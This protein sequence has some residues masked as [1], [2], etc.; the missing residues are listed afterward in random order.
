M[1]SVFYGIETLNKKDMTNEEKFSK[2]LQDFK[3]K[4]PS[5]T[6]ADLQTFTI[7]WQEAVKTV[8]YPMLWGEANSYWRLQSMSITTLTI[9]RVR[10]QKN[11]W[12]I[13]LANN[14]L[15]RSVVWQVAD[16]KTLTC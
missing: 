9:V 4:Y 15:Q 14:C 1:K 3:T 7:S 6:S 10:Q 8:L 11:I 2:A 13:F 16:L 5:I 12:K